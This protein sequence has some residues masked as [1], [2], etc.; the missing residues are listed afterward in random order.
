MTD[1]MDTPNNQQRLAEDAVKASELV[2]HLQGLGL[3]VNVRYDRAVGDDV[4]VKAPDGTELGRAALHDIGRKN[5]PAPLLD[6]L[7]AAIGARK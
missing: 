7:T 1:V 2:A 4:V 6:K 3:T 5:T